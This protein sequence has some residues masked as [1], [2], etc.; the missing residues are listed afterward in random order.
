MIWHDSSV[1]KVCTTRTRYMSCLSASLS[2]TRRFP[3]SPV[4]TS[5]TNYTL[6]KSTF[7]ADSKMLNFN[8]N[9]QCFGAQRFTQSNVSRRDAPFRADIFWL[10]K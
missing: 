4:V 3:I 6:T 2:D 5:I 9:G 7:S 1:S 8:I 10:S